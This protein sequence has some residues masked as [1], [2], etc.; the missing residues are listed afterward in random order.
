MEVLHVL[1]Y[2][3]K[4]NKNAPKLVDIALKTLCITVNNHSMNYP[5][6]N[7]IRSLLQKKEH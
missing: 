3:M 4:Y 7:L 1:Q 6:W 5:T 2:L